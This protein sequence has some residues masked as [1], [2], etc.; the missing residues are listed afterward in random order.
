MTSP[1]PIFTIGHSTHSIENFLSL[2]G[3]HRVTAI[4]DVRSKPASRFNPQ[5]NREALTRSVESVG[6]K[7]VFLGRELGARSNDPTCYVE[8]KVQYERLAQVEGFQEGISRLLQGRSTESIAVMCAEKDPLDCHRTL[9]VA[10]AL[11]ERSAEV[12][13]IAADGSVERHA[14]AMLRM[15][16][17]H[18][19]AEDDL[20]QTFDE[21]LQMALERQEDKIAY[22][23]PTSV[24]EA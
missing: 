24:R 1:H 19:L 10:R 12:G 14:D 3:R 18:G 22:V 5:F 13:H 23:E 6:I 21:R 20:F 8:G 9:L 4:A 2:L 7:Y 11:A 17:L 15:M 16:L